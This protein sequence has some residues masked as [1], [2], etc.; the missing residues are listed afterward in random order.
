MLGHIPML[1]PSR[2]DL[3][4]HENVEDTKRGRDQEEIARQHG[5]RVIAHERAPA[6]RPRTIAR[7]TT[8][9][10]V[11]PYRPRGDVDAQLH[12]QLAGNPLLAPDA[13]RQRHV[14][15]QSP[16]VDRQPRSAT[17]TRFPPPQQLKAFAMPANQRIWL[18]DR[19]HLTPIDQP[20]QTDER[21]P[22]RIVGATWLYLALHVKASCFR[23]NRFSAESWARDRTAPATNRRRSSMRQTIVRTATR[24][25]DVGLV[26]Q[27]RIQLRK[28][29]PWPD[30]DGSCLPDF[31]GIQ[32]GRIF[33]AR[34]PYPRRGVP[35][36][37]VEFQ[38]RGTRLRA[39]IDGQAMQIELRSAGDVVILDLRGNLTLGD[40]D[41][42]LQRAVSSLVNE[43]RRQIVLNLADVSSIDSAC[44]GEIVR[45][46]TTVSRRGGHVQLSNVRKEI[47]ELFSVTKLA[48]LFVLVEK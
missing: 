43:G 22:R 48:Y 27:D 31:S 26:S 39:S 12:E 35:Y 2:A 6:L 45:T 28:P 40:G 18:H 33:C 46:Y 34:H 13:I 15:D 11:T 38:L 17:W 23:R 20:P 9:R 24:D 36:L 44:L 14:S 1:D 29:R 41:E 8:R 32:P 3:Q 19:E 42:Q 4:H 30:A 10:D 16:Y 25:L 7:C 37:C 21:D 47:R 5:A